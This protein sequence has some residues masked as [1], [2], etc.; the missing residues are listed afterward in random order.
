MLKAL[1]IHYLHNPYSRLH[2]YPQI[3]DGTHFCRI[4]IRQDTDK[5]TDKSK[6]EKGQ[7]CNIYVV[8]WVYYD[9]YVGCRG[10]EIRSDQ[11][12]PVYRWTGWRRERERDGPATDLFALKGNICAGAKVHS[13]C[14]GFDCLIYILQKLKVQILYLG[15]TLVGPVQ[16]ESQTY[17][18]L[19]NSHRC[20]PPHPSLSHTPLHWLHLHWAAVTY[21]KTTQRVQY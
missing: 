4:Q 13:V 10:W 7:S 8:L 11:N 19:G 9:H 16:T 17:R 14:V 5:D 1:H 3:G 18:H 20:N 21:P 15:F 12:C 2:Y 6:P